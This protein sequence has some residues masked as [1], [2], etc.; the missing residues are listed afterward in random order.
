MVAALNLKRGQAMKFRNL[1]AVMAL[2]PLLASCAMVGETIEPEVRLADIRMM[3][4]GGIFEQKVGV[5][6]RIVNPNDFDI[7]IDGARFRLDV[8]D[9]PFASGVSKDSI[10]VPRLSDATLIGEAS[11][12]M[13]DVFRQVFAMSQREAL[14][15]RLTGTLFSGMFTRKNLNFDRAGKLDFAK[16]FGGREGKSAGG[17][18]LERRMKP[19]AESDLK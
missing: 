16:E 18:S 17:G 4:S 8:N 13:L 19:F 3:E 15:Y 6:L 14:S 10:T 1:L 12:G 7:S 5:V 11:V 2:L 9:Q